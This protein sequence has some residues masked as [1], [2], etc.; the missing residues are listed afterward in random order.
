M[1]TRQNQNDAAAIDWDEVLTPPQDLAAAT[2]ELIPTTRPCRPSSS[3]NLRSRSATVPSCGSRCS[4][5]RPPPPLPAAV[6]GRAHRHLG[7]VL[8]ARPVDRVP[9]SRHL[10][11]GHRDRAGH[12]RRASAA[13]A[14]RRDG[15]RLRHG[16][17]RQGPAGYIHSVAHGEG[18]AGGLYPLLLPAA[19]EGRAVPRRRERRAGE[20]R[21]AQAAAS[22]STSDRPH[23][24]RARLTAALTTLEEYAPELVVIG[25]GMGG[26]AC[27]MRARRL[28]ARVAVIEPEA[29]G[30]T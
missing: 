19:H 8:D 27:A 17:T 7:A 3:S 18:P 15:G 2:R 5:R 1:V 24:P 26:I 29:L 13:A 30:G 21:R 12:G 11:R 23:R 4:C 9:R 22:W 20:R 10:G 16:D 6:R 25:G 28:G 14:D